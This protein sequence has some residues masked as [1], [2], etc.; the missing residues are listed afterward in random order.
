MSNRFRYSSRRKRRAMI[1]LIALLLLGGQ[2]GMALL[3]TEI[4]Q[5]AIDQ[6]M[7]GLAK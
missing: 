2:K 4:F 1:D 7:E 3:K 6:M 5:S